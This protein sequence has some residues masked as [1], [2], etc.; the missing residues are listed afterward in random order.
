MKF[1]PNDPKEFHS[2]YIAHEIGHL[3]CAYY[4]GFVI[5]KYR[6]LMIYRQHTGGVTC[7]PNRELKKDDENEYWSTRAIELLA[8]EIAVRKHVGLPLDQIVF[9]SGFA[10]KIVSTTSF[11]LVKREFKKANPTG[12]DDLA[13]VFEIITF[14]KVETNWWDWL[15]EKHS[16]A[17]KVIDLIFNKEVYEALSDVMLKCKS[18]VLN[19]YEGDSISGSV[20]VEICGFLGIP[21]KD[22][23]YMPVG[24]VKED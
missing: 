11:E 14:L 16:E 18:S 1:I 22:K 15:S 2:E 21:I 17:V 13:K 19:N 5:A 9:R 23:R 24:L 6:G 20:I 4:Y 10:G 12:H 3:V 8:A 7:E